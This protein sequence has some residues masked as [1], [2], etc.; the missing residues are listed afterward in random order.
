MKRTTPVTVFGKEIELRNYICSPLGGQEVED[1]KVN[2]YIMATGNCN[3]K[4]F[5]CPGY[6]RNTKMDYGKLREVLQELKHKDL[7]NRISITGGEPM[8]DLLRLEHLLGVLKEEVPEYHISLNTNGTNLNLGVMEYM[9][10]LDVLSDIHVSRHHFEDG[11]NRHIFATHKTATATHLK[12]AAATI[13]KDKL[14]LSCNLMK[15]F[16]DNKRMIKDYMEHAAIIGAKFVGFVSLM[17]KTEACKDRYVDY[18]DISKSFML[19]DRI[20]YDQHQSDF[21]SCKCENWN[22]I[23]ANGSA[24]PFYMRHVLAKTCDCVKSFCYTEDN[25]LTINH[26]GKVVL[27]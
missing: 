1:P 20:V 3:A 25:Q 24:I 15:G 8:L 6:N 4:C 21:D 17:D 11:W 2:L 18:E 9:E 10:N 19:S 14:S 22:Y 26:N 23:A 27:Y 5:F 7:I 13:L 16:I 12:C